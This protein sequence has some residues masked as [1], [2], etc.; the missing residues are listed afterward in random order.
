MLDAGWPPAV[1]G[2]AVTA[3]HWAA[4]HGNAELAA[5]LLARRAARRSWPHAGRTPQLGHTMPPNTRGTPTAP[6][7]AP[8][9]ICSNRE[10]VDP[11][12]G[13]Y[14]PPVHHLRARD[15]RP[16]A[17]SAGLRQ[18]AAAAPGHRSAGQRHLARQPRSDERADPP[19]SAAAR[20]DPAPPP[21]LSY[22]LGGVTYLSR[23]AARSPT[24]TSPS[25][26][27]RRDEIH[28]DRSASTMAR[29]QREADRP[30]PAP[31]PPP[32]AGSVVF[33]AWVDG[34]KVFESDVMHRGDA[35]K[36]VSI[37]LAGRAEARARGDRRQRRH[38]RRQRGLGRRGDRRA[39][40]TARRQIQTLVTTAN[41]A[42]DRAE[43]V[44]E[45]KA[46]RRPRR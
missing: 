15:R 18:D 46:G 2:Q 33:G 24:P 6:T 23:A 19:C 21:P 44:S 32:R 30:R 43:S 17:A 4:Y 10:S 1:D 14:P 28:R 16:R 34:R 41:R 5:A 8:C 31:A 20:A 13:A 27:R 39:A 40:G 12:H 42:A 22:R 38:R 25:S 35:P 9:W 3:L 11:R 29:R 45:I 26:R 37:D 36:P 7:T